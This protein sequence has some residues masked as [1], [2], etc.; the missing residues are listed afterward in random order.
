[1]DI[2]NYLLSFVVIPLLGLLLTLL[3]PS[4]KEHAISAIAIGTTALHF[5]YTALFIIYWWATGRQHLNVEEVI[6]YQSKDYKFFID[7][8]FNEVTAVYLFTGNFITFLITRYSRY[9][10]ALRKWLQP[11]FQYYF[12]FLPGL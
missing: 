9:L 4:K 10:H 3:I 6:L 11:F 7:F 12:V 1:M 2:N 5:F 8:Y